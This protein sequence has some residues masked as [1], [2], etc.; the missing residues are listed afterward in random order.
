VPDRDHGSLRLNPSGLFADAAA[1]IETA[2]GQIPE[3]A[4]TTD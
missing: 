3:V 1:V 2:D 4:F